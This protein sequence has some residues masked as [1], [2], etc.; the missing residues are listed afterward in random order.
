MIE[1]EIRLNYAIGKVIAVNL[2]EKQYSVSNMIELI[3]R[4]DVLVNLKTCTD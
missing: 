3:Y 2:I 4:L 1:F